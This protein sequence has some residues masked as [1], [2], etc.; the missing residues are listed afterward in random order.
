MRGAVLSSSFLQS[1]SFFLPHT[2]SFFCQVLVVV[3][4]QFIAEETLKG[5]EERCVSWVF[6]FP[7]RCA[8]HNL[9]YSRK[10]TKV[11]Q[12]HLWNSYLSRLRWFSPLEF[13]KPLGI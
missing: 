10:E 13:G 1:P 5:R 3:K 2:L 11:G 6:V 7:F 4:K 9:S 8:F 12:Q